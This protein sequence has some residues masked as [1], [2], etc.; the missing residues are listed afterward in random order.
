M[1]KDD[2]EVGGENVDVLAPNAIERLSC[3]ARVVDD[4]GCAVVK[5]SLLLLLSEMVLA[6]LDNVA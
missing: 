2:N 4:R 5:S 1:A 6:E 3:V